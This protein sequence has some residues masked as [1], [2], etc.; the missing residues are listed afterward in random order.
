MSLTSNPETR[1]I[2]FLMETAFHYDVYA[3][4]ISAL[5]DKGIPCDIIINDVIE[6]EFVN[7]MVSFLGTINVPGLRFMLLSAVLKSA[8]VYDCLVS[9]YYLSYVEKI[10]RKHV[11]TVYGL[12]KNEWNHAAWNAKYDLILCYSHYTEKSLNLADRVKVIGNPRFDDWHKKRYPQALPSHISPHPSK[13]TLLYAPTYGELSSLPHWAEK[14][15]RLS[16]EYTLICKLH[17]GTLYKKEERQSLK[18]AKRFLKNIVK[19]NTSVFALLERADYVISDNSGFI[20]DAINA[21][22]KVILLRW[23]G[24]DELLVGNKSFSNPESPEQ[25]VRKLLPDARDMADLRYFLSEDYPWDKNAAAVEYI[26][27]EYCDAFNDGNAGL[28]AAEIIDE[29]TAG[30]RGE[31]S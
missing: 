14:L 2:G 9:P 12:A 23:E 27:T 1:C 8:K 25:Q 20:F 10:A 19:D 13:P 5:L 29:A 18:T 28:R 11:R 17:H 30:Y 21:D 4:I 3:N 15:G 6:A 24:M 16:N 7:N 31:S 22:K 26:K